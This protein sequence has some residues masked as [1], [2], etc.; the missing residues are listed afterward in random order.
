M[1]NLNRVS[2]IGRLTRDVELKTLAGG[3]Q[4]ARIGFAVNNR[5]K[6]ATTGT[7][8][9]EPVFMDVELWGRQAELAQQY[10]AKGRQCFIEG[11][12]KLDQWT[13]QQGQKRQKLVVI[14]ENLQ[15]L[16]A[17]HAKASELPTGERFPA[18]ENMSSQDIPF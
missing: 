1:A 12:L 17:A 15:F 10:L 6:D 7:Y 14:G 2:L 8:Q 13:D 18:Q 3:N 9:D 4:L 16:D 11:R 5:R